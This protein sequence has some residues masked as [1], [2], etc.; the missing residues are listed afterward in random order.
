MKKEN[1]RPKKASTW[2]NDDLAVVGIVIFGLGVLLFVA[3]T[4]PKT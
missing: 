1:D 3:L 4:F 2:T